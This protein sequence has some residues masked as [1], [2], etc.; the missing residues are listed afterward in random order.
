MVRL[1]ASPALLARLAAAG[2]ARAVELY[3][4]SKVADSVLAA[5]AL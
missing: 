5:L 2:H 3:D 4:A 1:V